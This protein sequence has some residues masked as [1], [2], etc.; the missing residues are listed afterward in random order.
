MNIAFVSTLNSPPVSFNVKQPA[1]F[2]EF[3]SP[4]HEQ[5][6]TNRFSGEHMAHMS[7]KNTVLLLLVMKTTI[8]KIP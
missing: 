4:L 6:I 5:P 8:N 1:V 3:Q 7:E 2:P